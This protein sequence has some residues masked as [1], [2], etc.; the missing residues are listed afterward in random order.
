MSGTLKKN[1]ST[2]DLGESVYFRTLD[3]TL[4]TAHIKTKSTTLSNISKV[5]KYCINIHNKYAKK[6]GELQKNY[7]NLK[8]LVCHI[9]EG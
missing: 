7:P 1:Y 6:Y 8:D 9:S 5:K 4:P 2:N 3:E